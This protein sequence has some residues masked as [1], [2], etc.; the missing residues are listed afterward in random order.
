[1]H[2]EAKKITL[3][4]LIVVLLALP[5]LIGQYALQIFIITMTYAMLGLS[6]A[7]TMR[8]GLPRFDIAAWWG[9]GAYTTA[10]LVT[11]AGFSFW[12]TI[13]VACIIA[14]VL[15]WLV[16]RVAVPRGMMVFLMFGMVVSL[17]IT[18]VFGSVEFFG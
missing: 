3:G 13:P 8:V 11:K 18:Q 17:A 5:W 4:I 12:A 6:F 2:T 7:F 14:V 9:I 1:M 16:F 15:G 10:T